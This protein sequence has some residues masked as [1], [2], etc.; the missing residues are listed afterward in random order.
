M[1]SPCIIAL[2]FQSRKEVEVFLK[3]FPNECLSVKIGM[4][5][6]YSEGPEMVQML[7]TA[8]HEI[9]L[10]LK[11]H[12]IPN[13]V[14][15]TMKQLASL[16]VDMV[17]VHAAGGTKMMRA[18][19]EG[20][21]EGTPIGKKRPICIAVTQL[22]STSEEQM[23]KEQW[24]EKPL[25]DTVVHFAKLAKESGLDGVVCSALEV[26]MISQAV[27]KDFCTVT[28]GIRMQTASM[29]DQVRV[30]TPDEARRLGS[31]YMVVGRNITKAENKKEAYTQIMKLWEEAKT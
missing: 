16:G 3:E 17:N 25:A 28:P 15:A 2:D 26:P 22:T 23:Q 5:L 10:D 31:T 8:G 24:I 30:V 14:R 4:E 19:M 11:L 12:D 29:D 1:K 21:K 18:A 27:G 6:Y 7:K 9:F 13:T 20:L